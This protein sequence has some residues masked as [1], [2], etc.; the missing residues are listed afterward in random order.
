MPFFVNV[1]S[2]NYVLFSIVILRAVL[3]LIVEILLLLFSIVLN[4]FKLLKE[5]VGPNQPGGD[6]DGVLCRGLLPAVSIVECFVK[7]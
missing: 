4:I 1:F 6:R 5:R 3:K 2:F 7:T